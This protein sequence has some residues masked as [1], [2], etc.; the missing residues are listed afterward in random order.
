LGKS[1]DE[2]VFTCS[3][4]WILDYDSKK[5]GVTALHVLDNADLQ[6]VELYISR[7]SNHRQ[8]DFFSSFEGL[9]MSKDLG[10]YERVDIRSDLLEA[11]IKW[12]LQNQDN[13]PFM[14]E[15]NLDPEFG[16]EPHPVLDI[17]FT[18]IPECM[19]NYP[20]FIVSKKEP[21][22]NSIFGHIGFHN[23]H[24]PTDPGLY[25]ETIS[26]PPKANQLLFGHRSV[27]LGLVK[28]SGSI[29]TVI[30]TN[31]E[32]SSGGC[33]VDDNVNVFGISFG[34]FFDNPNPEED[35]DTNTTESLPS[36]LLLDINIPEKGDPNSRAPR[37]RN[38]ALS[39]SQPGV[40]V[41]LKML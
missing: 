39:L 30:S 14:Q 23:E 32:G 12:I 4:W 41:C 38:L 13:I 26:K 9:R 24:E 34:S 17:L 20:G 37:N 36:G 8:I 3:S 5:V 40:V 25:D 33:L 6:T 35:T 16:L 10:L 7:N 27:S 15:H 1:E 28:T 22:Q 29:I 18:N 2:R 31:A 11:R 21:H 19:R